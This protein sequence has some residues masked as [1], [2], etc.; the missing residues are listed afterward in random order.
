MVM[1]M[2]SFVEYEEKTFTND[3]GTSTD[4]IVVT[5]SDVTSAGDVKRKTKEFSVYGEAEK[6]AFMRMRDGDR[7]E[8][9]CKKVSGIS[10]VSILESLDLFAEGR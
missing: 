9:S 7:F 8:C 3:D 6:L 5:Y 2:G 4:Y 1:L 10:N